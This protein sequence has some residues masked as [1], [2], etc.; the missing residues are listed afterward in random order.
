MKSLVA[1]LVHISV[2]WGG[3]IL[4]QTQSVHFTATVTQVF[5]QTGN[6]LALA[7]SLGIASGNTI[8]GRYFFDPNHPDG[9][10]D[11]N[12]GLYNNITA[13]FVINLQTAVTFYN[14][15]SDLNSIT[16]W[17]QAG[18]DEIDV[19]SLG[20]VTSNL[21]IGTAL[22]QMNIIWDDQ[23]AAAISSEALVAPP[24]IPWSFKRV[25]LLAFDDGN[26][27]QFGLFA[28]IDSFVASQQYV[29][30]NTND[31][32]PGSLRQAIL[33]AR[34]DSGPSNITFDSTVFPGTI[35]LLTRL[36]FLNDPGDSIEG[37][38][39]ATLNGTNLT[40][41]QD[42]GL[43]IF[44]SDT[45]IR[46]LKLQNFVTGSGIRIQPDPH[47]PSGQSDQVLTGILV[48]SNNI[49]RGE[50]GIVL[51]GG[52]SDNHIQAAITGNSLTHNLSDG[53][54]VNG[55]NTI[56]NGRN[57][58]DVTISNNSIANSEGRNSALQG[59]GI[60]V[61][62]GQGTNVGNNII[63]AS[64]SDN[65]SKDNADEGIRLAGAGTGS[66]SSNNQITASIVRNISNN[67]GF[68]NG[69]NGI[70][71][72]GGPTPTVPASTSGNLI[73]FLA[74]ENECS[75][76]SLYGIRLQGGEGSNH[77]VRGAIF[78]NQFSKNNLY[79]IFLHGRGSHTH[80]ENIDIQF[81]QVAQ[82]NDRGLV[83]FG[84]DNGETDNAAITNV[85]VNGNA[86][87]ANGH[88]GIVADLGTGVGNFISFAGITN[89]VTSNNAANGIV[90]ASGVNGDGTTP[91]SGNRADRNTGDR[92]GININSTG[93]ILSGNRAQRNAR[94]GI[95][96]FGNVDGG[97]NISRHNGDPSCDPAGCF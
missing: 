49:Q 32:G 36:P 82:N 16:I 77:V 88:H 11:P 74:A 1:F 52:E 92:D 15:Q 31:S 62:G 29:V 28:E 94:F 43:R 10:L 18:F 93:Y 8:S 14:F 70:T 25:R 91:I 33:D 53:I 81:N 86:I 72:T 95:K 17:N 58:I 61:T 71:V 57:R 24:Q 90:I 7:S 83:I 80:L 67:N 41:I 84:G 48:S 2:F 35:T 63:R 87:S 89:N 56:G 97:G 40:T 76:N 55:S 5:N 26:G 42:H 51:L 69:G 9:S 60:R 68:P 79:G 78:N 37:G 6:G 27:N 65:L 22:G 20:T 38:G 12:I 44:A 45:T 47:A 96:A 19:L 75:S 30:I 23:T 21:P 64:I 59:D 85:L 39:I 3:P 13:P 34:S 50:D 4:A 54:V 73:D 66:S 46:G